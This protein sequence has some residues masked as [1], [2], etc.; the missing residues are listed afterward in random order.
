VLSR[1]SAVPT[2]RREGPDAA[3]PEAPA[4]DLHNLV[5]RGLAWK[6]VSQVVLQPTTLAVVMVPSANPEPA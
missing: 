6:L 3:P 1:R 4:L 2:E 5:V